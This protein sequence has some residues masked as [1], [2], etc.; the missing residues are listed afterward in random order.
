MS[1]K[2]KSVVGLDNMDQIH[3]LYPG[4]MAIHNILGIF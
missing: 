4:D 2:V 3:D 1:T